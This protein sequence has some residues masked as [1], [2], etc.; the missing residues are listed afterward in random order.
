MNQTRQIITFL[1]ILFFAQN[2]KAQTLITGQN[3]N[4][5][6]YTILD[7]SILKEM[8]GILFYSEEEF[9]S[10]EEILAQRTYLEP[11][12]KKGDALAQ[13]LYSEALN[14]ANHQ[15]LIDYDNY[16]Y[17]LRKSALLGFWKAHK[18]LAKWHE[19]EL[20]TQK[21]FYHI[22][23]YRRLVND[24]FKS[25]VYAELA[26]F[27]QKNPSVTE[28]YIDSTIYYYE[29]AIASSKAHKNE[30]ESFP[31]IDKIGFP[32]AKLHFE[33]Q[34]Y[35]R[36]FD[37]LAHEWIGYDKSFRI[38]IQYLETIPNQPSITRDKAVKVLLEKTK[39]AIFYKEW[40]IAKLNE[41]HF[42]KQLLTQVEI[43]EY[44]QR[45]T[46]CDLGTFNYRPISAPNSA[47]NLGDIHNLKSRAFANTVLY[48]LT[49]HN[50]D[51]VKNL[52]Y[53]PT[54]HYQFYIPNDRKYGIGYKQDSSEMQWEHFEQIMDIPA[55]RLAYFS[56]EYQ[57]FKELARFSDIDQ[58]YC[59]EVG[60]AKLSGHQILESIWRLTVAIITKDDQRY[61]AEFYIGELK[62]NKR[63]VL[64]ETIENEDFNLSDLNYAYS[65]RTLKT[66]DNDI[67]FKGVNAFAETLKTG[68][69]DKIKPCFDNQYYEDAKRWLQRWAKSEGEVIE[70][71]DDEFLRNAITPLVEDFKYYGDENVKSF[72]EIKSFSNIEEVYFIRITPRA[73]P[74]DGG[75]WRILAVFVDKKGKHYIGNIFAKFEEHI[76]K[77]FIIG[78]IG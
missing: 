69:W 32:L 78:M 38:A 39:N 26:K 64:I 10:K 61:A 50:F 45:N 30:G 76:P 8:Y 9:Y 52:M 33:Q 1:I 70:D 75:Y 51:G 24:K 53:D 57:H 67:M 31:L 41:L 43:S 20:L 17:Y 54:K 22:Q 4:Y 34:N 15:Q 60:Y 16:L 47:S 23:Q 13:F 36:A 14:P 5:P 55:N 68:D 62:S 6:L 19:N 3:P 11:F 21:Q 12:A 29:A 35:D 77:C 58:V 49:T 27:H 71:I 74:Y 73:D 56:D 37:L 44:Y 40:M 72:S 18:S 66:I 46:K 7:T 2:A 25:G 42:C 28:H 63:Q 59:V 48:T 65:Q